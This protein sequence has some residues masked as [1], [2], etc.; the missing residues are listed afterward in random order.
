MTLGKI[1]RDVFDKVIYPNLGAV[2]KEVIVPPKNGVDVGVIDLGDE[3]VLVTKTDPVFIVPQYGFRKA[4][5]FAVHI[6]ASDLM[7][8][9]IP[10]QYAL[11]DLNLPPSMTDEEFE[12]MWKGIS[13]ALKEIGVMVVGGHT[14]RYEGVNYP[15]L[16]GFT[17]L[18]IGE[19]ERLA[20]P[21]K[22]KPGDKVVVTKGPAVEATALLVN[23]FPDYFKKR[24][25]ADVFQ[26]GLDM[27]WKMSCWKDG[28][29]ASN[30]G[31]H[32][33]H[34]ATEGGLWN[35]LVEVA[36]ASNLRIRVYKD[37]IPMYRAVKEV[38]KIVGID[39]FSSISEGTMVIVTDRG[40]EVKEALAK[41][42][43][44]AEVIGIV[45]EG[46]AEVLVDGKRIERPSY[47]PF[48]V[49]FSELSSRT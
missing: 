40:E 48:W 27:F 31:V 4:S 46:E 12:E 3:R 18:G 28:L 45:E 5:W 17:M 8:S 33:M 37:R 2:R 10:P 38:T 16:G 30:V 47:D 43:I 14:G 34:D 32:A 49:A 6:L 35:A 29:V 9:G 25:P 7:T 21:S 39:P 24:L 13:D 1:G 15:M 22:V 11:I 26:E 19:K 20:N 42:G 36:E 44:E 41:E 23:T